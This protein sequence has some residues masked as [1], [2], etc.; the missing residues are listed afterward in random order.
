MKVFFICL[1]TLVFIAC[2]QTEKGKANSIP[3]DKFNQIDNIVGTNNW[4]V[5]E[6]QDTSYLYFSRIGD[7]LINVYRYQINKG[8]SVNTHFNNI[9]HQ[10]DSV[11]W[12]WENEKL[13]LVASA[14]NAIQWA[15]VN[16][17]NSKYILQKTDSSHLSFVFPDGHKAIMKRTLPLSTFLVRKQYDYAHGTSYVDSLDFQLR[18]EKKK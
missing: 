3:K 12:N 11:I 10:Q 13:L 5:I 4:Q 18:S 2:N 17:P 7:A 16:D 8:D 1:L 9:T 15:L 14:D 6:G